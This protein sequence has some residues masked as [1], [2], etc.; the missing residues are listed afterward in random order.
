[1]SKAKTNNMIKRIVDAAMSHWSFVL[2][3]LHLGMHVPAVTAS[4]K[5]K[6]KTKAALAII[7][8]CIGGIGLWLFLRNGMPNYLLFRVPFAFLDY[9]KAGLLVFL[10]NLLMLFFWVFIGTLAALICRNAGGKVSSKI[11]RS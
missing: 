1:M 3:G 8:T 7:F 6:D 11:R 2:M 9:E 10:E 4:L 5:L